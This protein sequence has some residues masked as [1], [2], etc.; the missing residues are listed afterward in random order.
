MDGI[1]P[2][3]GGGHYEHGYTPATTSTPGMAAPTPG[4]PNAFTPAFTPANAYTPGTP[5]ALRALR[6]AGA[7][8]SPAV[9]ELH[10]TPSGVAA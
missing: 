2:T 7:A 4:M 3:P 8:L 1:A 6:P 9:C 10:D 5:G